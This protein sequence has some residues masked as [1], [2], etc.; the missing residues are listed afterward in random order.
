MKTYSR[1]YTLVEALLTVSLVGIVAL[2]VIPDISPTRDTRLEVAAQELADAIS[3]ARS[4]AIRTGT[5]H[6]VDVIINQN[7]VRLFSADTSTTPPTASFDVRHPLSKSLYDIRLDDNSFA[8]VGSINQSYTSN[9]VC[10]NPQRII[11]NAQGAAFCGDPYTSLYLQND[12][13]LTL[14]RGSKQVSLQGMS[15]GVRVQ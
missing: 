12:Y 13:R 8:D 1:G 9:G 5:A 11:F 10:S 7:R 15:G 4:E 6:G 3:F 2:V 14:D